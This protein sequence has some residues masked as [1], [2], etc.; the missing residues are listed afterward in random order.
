MCNPILWLWWYRGRPAAQ[1][2]AALEDLAEGLREAFDL[3]H[4]ARHFEKLKRASVDERHLFIPLHD[5][6]L[7]DS[8][9][10]GLMFDS[11]SLPPSAPPVPDF[12]TCL[13]L[14]PRFSRRVLLWSRG[15]G[16]EAFYPYN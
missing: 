13:W 3:P 15:T 12:I 14:A 5:S 1:L 11:D 2:I 6:C 4:V 16:W 9:A 10:L 8:L 7:P